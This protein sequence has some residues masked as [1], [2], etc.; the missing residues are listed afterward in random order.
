MR[1]LSSFWRAFPSLGLARSL[2]TK[3][4]TRPAAV[5][6]TA[7]C[8]YALAAALRAFA[9]RC[10][11]ASAIRSRAS[12]L[13]VRPVLLSFPPLWPRA[14]SALPTR[15]NSFWSRAYSCCRE[16]TTLFIIIDTPLLSRLTRPSKLRDN[17]GVNSMQSIYLVVTDFS[18]NCEMGY[19]SPWSGFGW[20][21]ASSARVSSPYFPEGPQAPAG[22]VCFFRRFLPHRGQKPRRLAG[23]G[24]LLE[25]ISQPN[26]RWFAPCR[27][28][29]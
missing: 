5:L 8:T 18:N 6:A 10:L 3:L 23:L 19:S 17:L 12:L 25:A 21:G 16:D 1:F 20:R 4:R 11:C 22:P 7:G 28:E 14:S 2:R 9:Q 15:P 13:K 26:E 27:P 24:R 29:K